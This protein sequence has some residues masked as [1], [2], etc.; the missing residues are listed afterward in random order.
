[1]IR[2]LFVLAALS[3]GALSRGAAVQRPGAP[4]H[5]A[6][7][8]LQS[9]DR[10][11]VLR[12]TDRGLRLSLVDRESRRVWGVTWSIEGA[13]RV[14]P[15]GTGSRGVVHERLA[16]GARTGLA[17]YSGVAYD[18]ILDGVQLDIEGRP[19]GFKTEL[20]C[21]AGVDAAAIRYRYDGVRTMELSTD[22]L[23]LAMTTGIG[24]MR[25][26]GLVVTQDG[27]RIAARFRDIRQEDA[28][29]WTY[30]IELGAHDPARPVVIDPTVT[31]SLFVGGSGIDGDGCVRA[32][33]AGNAYIAA[34]TASADMVV[35]GGWSGTLDGSADAYYAKL[36]PDGA[37]VWSTYFGGSGVEQM[38]QIIADAG[39]VYVAGQT[40]STNLPTVSPFQSSF[41]GLWDGYVAKLSS[42]GASILWCSYLGGAAQDNV[43]AGIRVDGSGSVFIGGTTQ[44]SSLPGTAGGFDAT[45]AGGEGYV[46]KITAS[47]VLAWSSFIGGSGDDGV[48][49]IAIDASGHLFAAGSTSSTDFPAT[50]GAYS[51]TPSGG[52]DAFVMKIGVSGAPTVVWATLVGGSGGDGFSGI[53]LDGAG[54]VVAGG[55]TQSTNY[56]T[57]NAAQSI[58][59]GTSDFV[60]TKIAADGAS[61]LWSTYLGGSATDNVRGL[62]VDASGNV[63][64]AGVTNSANFP[65]VS[66][67]F[68]TT[69]GGTWDG[70]VAKFTPGGVLSWS[71][72]VGGSN[73]DYVLSTDVNGTGLYLWG[74]TFSA[75]FPVTDGSS[76]GGMADGFV[77]RIDGTLPPGPMLAVSP[78]DLTFTAT[79]GGAAPAAQSAT[80]TNSGGG[81]MT[82]TA[83]GD[84][85]WL[86]ASS[87]SGS[88]GAGAS[89]TVSLAVDP[90]GLA[91]G[92]YIGTLS[93][94]GGTSTQTV[95]VHLTI[96][97]PPALLTVTP[98]S[99]SFAATAG[100]GNPTAQT[101]TVANTGGSQLSWTA[102]DNA[103]WVVESATSGALA[104]GAAT[105]ADVSVDIAGLAPGTYNAAISV[106]DGTA[107][108]T[109]AVQLVVNAAPGVLGVAPADLTF[110]ATQGGAAPAAQAVT[111]SNAGG[112][113]ISWGSGQSQSWILV[114]PAAGVL[115]AGAS[116]SMNVGV[117]S[118]GLAPGSYVG[119]VQLSDGVTTE[120]VTVRLTVAAPAAS[121]AADAGGRGKKCGASAGG[122]GSTWIV[123]VLALALVR[124]VRQEEP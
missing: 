65:G 56:P 31:Y 101:M 17:G 84:A 36:D 24:P 42:D 20:R 15:R 3:M 94:S 78:T 47:G 79:Q 92:I 87:T 66:G 30:G 105:N 96:N 112:S 71:S 48:G 124:K 110:A 38:A 16:N 117:D 123:I 63:Y 6:N 8:I 41:G 33:S 2:T 26:D 51:T 7:G 67:G 74:W 52:G 82:W 44:S 10:A 70:A 11:G 121:A 54:N 28:L 9:R 98:S 113:P 27:R 4:I 85:P 120:T 119:A 100:G 49:S 114:S 95:A 22:G 88:L 72:Y 89:S 23:S 111:V 68:Q 18:G 93:I 62:A 86:S 37:I 103:A 29:V 109:I 104:A 5:L 106:T 34:Y 108:K 58:L 76:L 115:A 57:L 14:A 102:S 64:A 50:A 45:S 55:T 83:S 53:G 97:T 39:S 35:V 90:A 75:N 99:L 80:V 59:A 1:M 43:N 107:T 19:C 122:A 13:N 73:A 40:D 61:L 60:V 32:D 46:A 118:A 25:E 116:Q 21:D 81:T 69:P 91:A 12:F 77:L